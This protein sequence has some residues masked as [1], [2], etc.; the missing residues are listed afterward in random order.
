MS[1]KTL[2]E[3]DHNI[4]RYSNCWEDADLLLRSLNPEKKAVVLSIG[5]AGDNSFSL[6]SSG[7][8]KVVCLDIN[9]TQLAL[10]RLKKAAFRTLEYEE[11]LQ[12]LG[13]VSGGP[14]KHWEKVKKALDAEDRQFWEQ[15]ITW[16][17][18][19]IIHQGKFEK[20]LQIFSRRVLPMI[21]SRKYIR[22]LFDPK[23]GTLQEQFYYHCWN[24]LRWRFFTRI[25]FSRSLLGA[26]R[27]PQF[28]K[29]VEGSVG[30]QIKRRIDRHL[31]NSACQH[32]GFLHY[33]LKGTFEDNLPHYARSENF[34]SIRNNLDALQTMEGSLEDLESRPV[35]THA[36]LSN[37]FEYQNKTTFKEN[38][39]KLQQVLLPGARLAYWNLL[40]TREIANLWP[41]QFQPLEVPGYETD[42][43]F[44]YKCFLLEQKI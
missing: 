7:A 16:L 30:K 20:F 15:R 21:H 13:F 33:M 41:E 24:N 44:F 17:K 32:N 42:K 1:A 39:E 40:V 29:Q 37:I 11:F 4:L 22:G 10:I 43:G 12:F 28:L 38:I 2:P 3:V 14:V 34:E 26:A 36:N 18:V 23:S 27:D 35:Y 19:G 31:S 8:E 25:F 5:S 6:L 9:T